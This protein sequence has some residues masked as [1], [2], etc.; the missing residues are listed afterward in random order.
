M[1]KY[2]KPMLNSINQEV[3]E[4]AIGLSAELRIALEKLL[5]DGKLDGIAKGVTEQVLTRGKPSLSAKQQHVF[6]RYVLT[7]HKLI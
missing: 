2:H 7:K 4:R 1:K 3:I 6:D 5:I